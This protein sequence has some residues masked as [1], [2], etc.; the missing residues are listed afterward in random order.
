MKIFPS[1]YCNLNHRIIENYPI[2]QLTPGR[3][4]PRKAITKES[5]EEL[6]RSIQSQGIIQPLI[7][8]KMENNRFEIIAGE[9]RWRAAK[10]AKL[11]KVPVIIH[12][13]ISDQT[14]MAMALIE[15]IQR[16]DLNVVEEAL[17]LQRL[18]KECEMT[19]E[20]V[21]EAVGRSRTAVSNLLRLLALS[22]EVRIYLENGQLEMGHAR[23]LLSLNAKDQIEVAKIIIEKRLTVRKTE[24]LVRNRQQN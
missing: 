18:I 16:E 9:R 11:S 22:N 6:V 2:N 10:E 13:T 24:D 21:A 12:E 4:Q 23:A 17:A 20:Q 14:A 15:N 8:K 7:V 1:I 19:H 5:L 3:Y